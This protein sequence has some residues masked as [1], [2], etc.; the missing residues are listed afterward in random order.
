VQGSNIKAKHFIKGGGEF[1]TVCYYLLTPA[2]KVY[3][4]YLLG[5]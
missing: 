2:R 5:V 1:I 3:K 4:K